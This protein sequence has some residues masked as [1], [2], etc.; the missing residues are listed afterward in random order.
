MLRISLF[1]HFE[2]TLHGQPIGAINTPRL[3]SLLAYLTLNRN[4]AISRRQLASLF[5]PDMLDSQ[6]RNNL[7]QMVHQL[8]QALPDADQF[9]QTDMQTLRWRS[10]ADFY[11]DVAEF[12]QAVAAASVAKKAGRLTEM[13]MQ[14]VKAASIFRGNLLPDC[15]DDW[16]TAERDRLHHKL[17]V[18]LTGLI[19]HYDGLRIF[20]SAIPYAQRLVEMDPID[21]GSQI[22]LLQLCV[23]SN[24]RAGAIHA[25]QAYSTILKKELGITPSQAICEIYAQ[26][27][28]T[29]APVAESESPPVIVEVAT[30]LVGRQA[31][32][33]RLLSAWQYASSGH[34]HMVLIS[35]EAGIGKTRLEIGR[36]HV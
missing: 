3:Q 29:Q 22:R 4:V 30:P 6:A 16:I 32:W 34:A 12:E 1:G 31:E 24:N 23:S 17:R 25:F 14:L 36:A 26:A 5:W 2:V 11:F 13:E 7:R 9:L 20:A 28:T 10:S 27:L 15:Y 35:G 21:E 33:Q 8:R 19:D 18:M